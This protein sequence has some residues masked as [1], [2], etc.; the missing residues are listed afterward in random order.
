MSGH[1]QIYMNDGREIHEYIEAKIVEG[2]EEAM[3]NLSIQVHHE[4]E[5]YM[6]PETIHVEL[7]FNGDI[8][9]DDCTYM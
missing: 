1:G 8:I 2:I 4:R 9:S 5:S 6:S 7:R 3:K